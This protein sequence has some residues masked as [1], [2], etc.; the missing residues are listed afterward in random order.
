MW[1]LGICLIWFESFWH[2]SSFAFSD[3]KELGS[4]CPWRACLV[5]EHT[6][7]YSRVC[8]K[9]KPASPGV[10][11]PAFL[12]WVSEWDSV[13]QSYLHLLSPLALQWLCCLLVLFILYLLNRVI[14]PIGGFYGDIPTHAW[15]G[16]WSYTP[17]PFFP[18]CNQTML[19]RGFVALYIVFENSADSFCFV[20]FFHSVNY[21]IP[22]PDAWRVTLYL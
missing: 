5:L 14:G 9:D 7:Y 16:I 15:M 22:L 19:L 10:C 18:S 6:C 4:C 1:F 11:G 20:L 3:S 2:V 21:L 12:Y 17:L 13:F 8:M